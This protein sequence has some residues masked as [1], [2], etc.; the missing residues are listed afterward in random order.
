[1]ELKRKANVKSWEAKQILE[2]HND[3]LYFFSSDVFSPFRMN[4]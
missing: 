1:M 4:E 2:S 3:K